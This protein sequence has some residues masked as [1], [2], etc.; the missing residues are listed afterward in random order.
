MQ[1]G[2]LCSVKK[3]RTKTMSGTR[4]IYGYNDLNHAILCMVKDVIFKGMDILI[5]AECEGGTITAPIEM[6]QW[7]EA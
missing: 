4:A 5:V 6:F 7:M 3:R 2:G 1:I